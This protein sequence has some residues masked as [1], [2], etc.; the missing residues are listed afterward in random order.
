MSFWRGF[1]TPW[2][3]GP[4][5]YSSCNILRRLGVWD[6][7]S[8]CYMGEWCLSMFKSCRAFSMFTAKLKEGMIM[9][10]HWALGTATS[11]AFVLYTILCT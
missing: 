7:D 4:W 5:F 9:H 11:E 3:Q 1:A 10:D 2:G 6:V 8:F